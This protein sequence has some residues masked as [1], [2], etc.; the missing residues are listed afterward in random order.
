MNP[1]NFF[2]ELKRRNV[3][4]VAVAYAIVAWLL[5][6]AASIILPTFDAPGWVMKVLIAALAIGFPL[7]VILAWAFEITPEGIVRAED[8]LPN[9]S[10]T[11]RTGRKLTAVIV[12][13]G[14]IA[15]GLLVFRFVRST[16]E[17]GRSESAPPATADQGAHSI[18]KS[19]AVLPFANL[20]SDEE[21]AFFA[22]GVQDE[23]LT[24]LSKITALKV[25]SRTSTQKYRSA[26]DNLRG[27][28]QELG[29]TNVLEGSVRKAG[30]Q[31]RITVQLINAATDAHL[32]AETYDRK[33]VDIFAVQTDVAQKIATALEARLTGSEK[34]AIAHVGTTNAEAYD[35]YLRALT[36]R[37]NQS[38]ATQ[39]RVLALC[40]RA[41]EL[42][43]NFAQAWALLATMESS[44]Y[45]GFDR[46]E[47]QLARAREA[48]EMA[49][50]LEPD[51]A[52]ARATM[53]AFKYYCLQDFEG[54]LR[55][56]ED[57]RAR[58]PNSGDILLSIGL[59]KR[60]Q[61]RLDESIAVHREAAEVD[62]RNTDVWMNLARSYRGARRFAEAHQMFDR[63][64]DVLPGDTTIRME[65]S[66]AFAA[67]GD[68]DAAESL[69]Q[70]ASYD[71]DDRSYGQQIN[72][73]TYR[74]RF[75]E[76]FT[77]IAADYEIEK[78]RV[79]P[80]IHALVPSV[81]GSLN[82]WKGDAAAAQP[83]LL[84]AEEALKKLRAEGNKSF[85]LHRQLLHVLA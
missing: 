39:E 29:V 41:V 74:R 11:R 4:K 28:A 59:V 79:S 65:K 6:Q 49:V 22:D 19:V 10:I 38:A 85:F 45:M 61:G 18:E 25:I 78:H 46:D 17:H 69:L 12:V 42:D 76:A 63:A 54:A 55:E 47:A 21:N 31:V 75:E 8:V 5:I 14:L 9:E 56:F 80:M 2:S 37:N 68:L 34:R 50:K 23:I 36:L 81:L 62:P 33:L 30:E 77:K 1:R 7:A 24:R 44:K 84:R 48:A 35:A 43:P 53:G 16:P 52:E 26:R 15:T 83:Y 73:L 82:V 70:G 57:A 66:E 60:R 51:L 32:W 13:V 72:L 64:L 3:Y 67:A 20:S 71:F 58:L 27:I 40:R